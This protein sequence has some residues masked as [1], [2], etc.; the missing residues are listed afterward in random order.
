M[1]IVQIIG[2][3]NAIYLSL[4]LFMALSVSIVVF[5]FRQGL[6]YNDILLTKF[7]SSGSGGGCLIGLIL[8]VVGLVIIFT[9]SDLGP[10]ELA[11]ENSENKMTKN[12]QIFFGSTIV[13]I[14]I[15]AA[16]LVGVGAPAKA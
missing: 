1:P 11:T 15:G 13:L 2:V 3:G 9:A 8:T 16:S 12:E 14:G 4:A 6:S 7:T 5:Y 10:S